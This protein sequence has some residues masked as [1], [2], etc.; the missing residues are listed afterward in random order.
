VILEYRWWCFKH[1]HLADR[2]DPAPV[3]TPV[4]D[5]LFSVADKAS[6]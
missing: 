1:A 2:A 4:P 3:T 5:D 6:R